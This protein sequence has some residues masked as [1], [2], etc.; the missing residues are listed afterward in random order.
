[1]R[2]SVA[3]ALVFITAASVLVLEILALRI[4]APYVGVT[5][6]TF[7][8]I[9]GTVLA[10][11]A[12]GAWLGGLAADRYD[13][14]ALL[15]PV[16]VVGGV[17]VIATP[18]V[19]TAVGPALGG[20]SAVQIVLL[21]VIGFFLPAAVLSAVAPIVA[22]LVLRTLDETGAVVGRLSA[23]GTAGAIFGTFV[24]GFLLV[25][26][27]P[28][29]PIT[30]VV[31]GLL[32]VIGVVI[33]IPDLRRWVLVGAV[34]LLFVALGLAVVI[35]GPCDVETAYFCVQIKVDPDRPSGRSLILDTL[36]HSY[37]D[38]EDPTYLGSRYARVIAAA[39][40]ATQPEGAI[41]TI[42]I[43]G[44]GFTLPRHQQ[45]TR[46]GTATVLEI[47]EE[48]VNVV[49]ERLVLPSGPWL[50]VR[51]GDARMGLADAGEGAFDVVV[52]DAFGGP[53]VPWHLTTVE[54]VTEIR[55]RLGP[56]GIYVLNLI[57]HPP[58]RFARAEAATLRAVFPHVAV[59]A[60]P[61]L[62]DGERG[63]NFVLVGSNAPLDRSAL[64]FA[65]Q[66][67]ETV[68][69]DAE[70]APFAAT[71]RILRDEYA[72]VDQLLGRP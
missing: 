63:G 18:A 46:G 5:L 53:S 2:S 58:N 66:D 56:D 51:I 68:L 8:G 20:E 4:L 19:V 39:V 21:A 69:V 70:A 15:G 36:R 29:R 26:A 11:I 65:M 38:L 47:D 57:D 59:I 40:D 61:P 34:P 52:G 28:S 41:D 22:K 31:G 30:W 32:I 23:L 44:G 12:V 60:H 25:A 13:P 71:A 37:V 67:G 24:T 49:A 33:T 48:L 7:T 72:P 55:D 6:Q 50:S 27:L 64:I 62:L 14:E 16:L 45:A 42:Y 10:G 3:G 35:Q 9:I 54:F 17:L 43:G 1:M